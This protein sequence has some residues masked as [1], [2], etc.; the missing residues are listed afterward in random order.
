MARGAF[1]LVEASSNSATALRRRRDQDR[2]EQFLP[3]AGHTP[4]PS[5]RAVKP[6]DQ[7]PVRGVVRRPMKPPSKFLA[8]PASKRRNT[9]FN[10]TFGVSPAE[11][12]VA[13]QELAALS[14]GDATEVVW[15]LK[16]ELRFRRTPEEPD[17]LA[18][19]C[20]FDVAA[21]EQRRR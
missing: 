14:P 9:K 18:V 8:T 10:V 3:D 1:F 6:L 13:A 11:L 16:G 5:S 2:H 17:R 7:S 4:V 15:Q 19:Q 12:A 21:I 20:S